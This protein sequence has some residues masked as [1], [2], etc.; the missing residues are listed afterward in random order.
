MQTNLPQSTG[1][2]SSEECVSV[3]ASA[4]FQLEVSQLFITEPQSSETRAEI[5]DE[6]YPSL[7]SKYLCCVRAKRSVPPEAS[8]EVITV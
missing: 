7:C 8:S 4:S 1:S 3:A 5:K 2:S 6:T